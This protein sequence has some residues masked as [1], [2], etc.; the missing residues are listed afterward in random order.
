V[1]PY[2]WG[3]SLGKHGWKLMTSPDSDLLQATIPNRSSATWREIAAG[4]EALQLG[5]IKRISDGLTVSLWTDKWIPRSRTMQPSFQLHD[6]ENNVEEINLV[7]ELIDHDIG[8]W[9]IDMVK[10]IFIPLEADAILNIP[11]RRDRGDDFWA[12]S[13]EKAGNYTVKIVYRM[14]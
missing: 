9:N 2:T 4:R 6:D 13:L 11:L 12:W 14:D 5:L 8:C 1:I 3:L 7:P 10:R